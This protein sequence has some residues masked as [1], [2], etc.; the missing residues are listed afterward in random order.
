M[1]SERFELRLSGKEKEKL[2]ADAKKTGMSASSYIRALINRERPDTSEDYE[3][4]QKLI[5]EINAI[6][7]N[8]NQIARKFNSG[9]FNEYEKRSLFSMMSTLIKNTEQIINRN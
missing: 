2:L 9:I 1:N 6:G 4:I 7:N 5:K 8:I 3:Q